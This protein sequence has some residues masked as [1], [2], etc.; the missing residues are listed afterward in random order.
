[1]GDPVRKIGVV[2]L[3]SRLDP[4]AADRVS[5]LAQELYPNQP[6]NI[7][8]HPQCFESWGHFAGTDEA[9]SGAFVDVANDA[10]YDAVWFARGGYGACRLVEKILPQLNEAAASKTYLGYSDAGTVLAG[11]YGLGYSRL[12]HGPMPTD[13]NRRD[14]QVAVE[15]AL[16]FL[17]EGRTDGVEAS[18]ANGVPAAAFN[19]IIF[20]QLLGTPWQPDLSGHVL[21]LEEVSEYMYRIDRT[22]CHITSNPGVREVAGI[23]LGRC[24][25]IPDNDPDFKQTEEQVVQH[26]CEV[27]G[28]PYLGRAD[29]GHDIENKIVPFGTAAAVG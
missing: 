13:I 24:S 29:I 7:V 9:R 6:P 19:M 10:S 27:S 11:L 14:G 21:M 23:R 17:V 1:M 26:W 15:R 16:R 4:A 8:F 3:G 20:S 18:L 5:K 28:I 22:L 25:D 2:A 12:A